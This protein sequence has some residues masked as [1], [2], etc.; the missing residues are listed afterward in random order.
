MVA[1]GP[2]TG[3]CKRPGTPGSA[4]A[5]CRDA[6]AS[7]ELDSR[8]PSGGKHSLTSTCASLQLAPPAVRRSSSSKDGRSAASASLTVAAAAARTARLRR[9]ACRGQ[10]GWAAGEATRGLCVQQGVPPSTLQW[11]CD[12]GGQHKTALLSIAILMQAALLVMVESSSLRGDGPGDG[13][14]AACRRRAA[15]SGGTAALAAFRPVTLLV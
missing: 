15:V 13:G 9:T 11:E 1:V 10:H 3:L 12:G 6:A 4:Q 14:H 2:P 8:R 7:N 5:M